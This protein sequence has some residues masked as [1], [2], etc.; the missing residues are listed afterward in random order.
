MAVSRVDWAD[1]FFFYLS[2]LII[3]VYRLSWFNHGSIM[4]I[5]VLS[6]IIVDQKWLGETENYNISLYSTNEISWQP[7]GRVVKIPLLYYVIF[8]QTHIRKT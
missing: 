7:R 1:F 2:N 8:K 3:M 5:A 6:L 4:I